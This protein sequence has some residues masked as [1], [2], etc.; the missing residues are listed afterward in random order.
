MLA[1]NTN[2]HDVALIER[3]KQQ[4]PELAV[5]AYR[6]TCT[7]A[8]QRALVHAARERCLQC[9]SDAEWAAMLL[10]CLAHGYTLH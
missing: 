4:T 1:A 2:A 3:V 10:V 9:L 8:Q 6:V 7:L 5:L